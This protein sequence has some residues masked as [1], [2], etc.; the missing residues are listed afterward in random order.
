MLVFILTSR[1]SE[2]VVR[3]CESRNLRLYC[4]CTLRERERNANRR[5]D[6]VHSTSSPGE[7]I[8]VPGQEVEVEDGSLEDEGNDN[9]I[10]AFNDDSHD[11]LCL[12]QCARLDG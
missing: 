8:S 6:F 5:K 9:R 7:D 2:V 12:H 11:E 4:V 3:S 1:L 10:N